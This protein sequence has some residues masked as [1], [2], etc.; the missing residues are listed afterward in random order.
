MSWQPPK[1]DSQGRYMLGDWRPTRNAIDAAKALL[2]E[3]QAIEQRDW[4]LVVL[5]HDHLTQE[6]RPSCVNCRTRI[7]WHEAIRCLDCKAPL[8]ETCAPNHFWPNGRQSSAH[9]HR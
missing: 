4:N 1:P 2:G 8:C 9:D 5:A 6:A 3:P 7:A